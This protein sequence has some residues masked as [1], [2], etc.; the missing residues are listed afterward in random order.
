VIAAPPIT[1]R[2]IDPD[3]DAALAVENYHDA[4]IASFGDESRYQGA[5]KYLSWL[6][7]RIEEFPDGHVLAMLGDRC[8]G[9]LELQVPYGLTV[10]YVNLFCVTPPFRGLGFARTLHQYADRYFRSWEA[11][12]IELHVSST[13]HRAVGFYRAMGYRFVRQENGLWEMAR[14]LI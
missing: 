12:R 3:A 4:C 14:H 11:T 1:Y 2:T 6:R 13:N 7:G 9:Q 5:A 10:G 8:I